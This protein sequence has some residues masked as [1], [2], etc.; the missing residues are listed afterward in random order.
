MEVFSPDGTIQQ[1]EIPRRQVPP[2]QR[3]DLVFVGVG[4]DAM[5]KAILAKTG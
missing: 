4:L 2:A 3:F 5:T 1:V